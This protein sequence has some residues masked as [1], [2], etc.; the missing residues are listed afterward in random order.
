MSDHLTRAKEYI[1]KG[2]D[3][4]AKAADEIQ[5]W[6]DEDAARTHAQAAERIGRGRLWVER[7]LR[8]RTNRDEGVTQDFEVDWQSG[9]NKRDE[10]AAK[11]MS[12][13]EQRRQVIASLPPDQ[14][15][16]VIAEANDVAVERVRAKQAEHNTAPKSA[17]AGDLMGG[18][19]FDPSESW[20]DTFIIRVREKAHS[21]RRQVE[22]WGLV[23]GSMDDEQAF[24][25]LQEAERN[26]AEVRAAL[27][28]RMADRSR[29]EV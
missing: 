23:I 29:S 1:A 16:A 9:S 26:I 5:A 14:I 18:D 20:A 13:P 4:Y 15:E 28:E 12:D 21:L 3:F 7:L 24:E 2:D 27:Q 22:K 8:A 10:V 6:L 19:S 25:Y 11:V 17:T